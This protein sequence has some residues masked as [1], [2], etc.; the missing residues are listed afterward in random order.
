[1]KPFETFSIPVLSTL[2]YYT[3]KAVQNNSSTRPIQVS[4][5]LKQTC[6]I[7]P[8]H[9]GVCCDSRHSVDTHL[10]PQQVVVL[11]WRGGVDNLNVDIVSIYT[12]LLAVR[13]L[14]KMGKR[15]Q[16]VTAGIG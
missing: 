6:F 12:I 15:H 2:S 11:R 14:Q 7:G 16:T 3:P 5:S 8:K 9:S 4:L 1:M 13:Q 10:S